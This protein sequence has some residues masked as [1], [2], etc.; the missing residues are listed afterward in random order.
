[1]K[2][3]TALFCLLLMMAPAQAAVTLK[4]AS[5]VPDGT[6]WMKE[7]RAAGNDIEEQTEGRVKFKFYPGGVQGSDKSV[8]RKMRIGQLQGGAL[9]TGAFDDIAPTAQLYSLPFTFRS[10]EELRAVREEYDP[11]IYKA[12]AQ[13]GYTVLGL[14]EGGFAYLMSDKPITSS[15]QVKDHKVWVPEGDQ[16]S[17]T[18]F[19]MGGVDPVV[20]PVSDVYTS[21]QTGLIDTLAVN[22]TAA[23]ALQWYTKLS[24][25][26]DYPLVYII[27]MLVVDQKAF[28]KISADD[29]VIVQARMKQAF[30]TMSEI[31]ETDEVNARAAMENNG[32]EFVSLSED[33]KAA[34]RDL[35][36]RS[37]SKLADDDVYP[38]ELFQQL[39]QRLDEV[40]AEMGS[41]AE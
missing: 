9:S 38:T 24:Y 7:M 40:R 6:S 29:Q 12:M 22:L 18:T 5:L 2:Q 1:M 13:K 11:Y 26:T 23:I 30:D 31:N 33:D 35:A 19:E 28:N 10:L 4:I 41:S 3:L 36:E 14:S 15:D 34:W 25:V 16:V 32:V 39:Q 37:L 20:L 17:Q 21:L 8:L 27:G